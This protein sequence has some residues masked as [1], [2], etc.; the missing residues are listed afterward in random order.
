MNIEEQIKQEVIKFTDWLW[1]NVD[2]KEMST[3]NWEYWYEYY[4]N[5]I[6][7]GRK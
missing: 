5:E 6:E 4:K 1:K 2:E 3:E 7:N